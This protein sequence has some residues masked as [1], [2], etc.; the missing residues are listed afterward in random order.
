MRKFLFVLLVFS[1]GLDVGNFLPFQHFHAPEDQLALRINKIF[2][3]YGY[4]A[5]E[6]KGPSIIL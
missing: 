6:L 3:S 5:G 2:V 1:Y 4:K